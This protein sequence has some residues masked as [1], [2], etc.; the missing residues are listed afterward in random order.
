MRCTAKKTVRRIVASGNDYLIKVKANQPRLLKA[1][2]AT[3]STTE[4]LD[5]FSQSERNRGRA[6][7][8]RVAVY[9]APSQV[10]PDWVE[11]RRVLYVER[12]G[13]RDGEPYHRVGYYMSSLVADA[14]CFAQGL[15]G[16]WLIENQ[17]H[18]VKDVQA[19]EDG[20]GI[21]SKSGAATLSLLKSIVLTLYR[22]QGHRSL[23]AANEHFANKVK[24]LYKILRT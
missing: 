10:D 11:L 8:R 23:K 7:Q 6:E 24:E 22:R 20:S 13:V 17:L 4:A 18:Y 16:H 12:S 9:R 15:R 2:E 1:L 5:T 14:Q 3:V 21:R 19:N